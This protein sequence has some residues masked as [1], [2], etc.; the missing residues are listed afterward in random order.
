M[1]KILTEWQKYIKESVSPAEIEQ[2]IDSLEALKSKAAAG[3]ADVSVAA[4]PVADNMKAALDAHA[5][6]KK[7][8]KAKN[9]EEA[10]K[11]FSDAYQKSKRP[12]TMY[13]TA[14]SYEMAGRTDMAVMI[15]KKYINLPNVSPEGKTAAENKIKALGN[16]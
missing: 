10:A 8:F 2:V 11:K 3:S 7:L 5:E 4:P 12:A 1:K 15:F 6:G 9:Y 14:R 13:N 16:R